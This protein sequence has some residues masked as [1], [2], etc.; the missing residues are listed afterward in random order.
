ML[1]AVLVFPYLDRMPGGLARGYFFRF[2]FVELLLVMYILF[3]LGL[4]SVAIGMRHMRRAGMPSGRK[5][6]LVGW[7]VVVKGW[8]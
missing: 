3:L 7:Q 5:N 4:K 8:P 2:L 6:A 1:H